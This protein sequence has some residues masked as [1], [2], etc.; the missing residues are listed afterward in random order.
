MMIYENKF[1][2]ALNWRYATKVFDSSKKVSEED[3]NELLEA[4]RLSASSFGLQP[5][6]VLVIKDKEL[7]KKLR[8]QAWN[9]P[10]VSDASHFVVFCART[11]LNEEYI[12]NFL[13]NVSETRGIPMENL[14]EFKGML[15]NF[16]NA[17]DNKS[18]IEWAKKQ[19]YIALGTL[20]S[21]CAL[22]EIDACPMEGFEP[23]KFDETLG[24]EKENLASAVICAIGHRSSEDKTAEYKKVRFKKED[25]FLDK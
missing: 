6:K 3:F 17:L 15:M 5:W 2:D 9:Q 18:K 1:I 4:V 20:L 22:K 23:A 13:K 14:K 24:L 11:D 19:A 8:E 25:L 16:I 10:Q 21:A 7:R 12:D